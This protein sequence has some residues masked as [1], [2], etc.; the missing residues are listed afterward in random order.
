MTHADV[1]EFRLRLDAIERGQRRHG[2]GHDG[3]G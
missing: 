1:K 3:A 2:P